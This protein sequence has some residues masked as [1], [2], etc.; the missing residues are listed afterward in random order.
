MGKSS[1]SRSIKNLWNSLYDNDAC[2]FLNKVIEGRSAMKIKSSSSELKRVSS[3]RTYTDSSNSD[4]DEAEDNDKRLR[5]SLRK[6]PP[7]ELLEKLPKPKKIKRTDSDLTQH[8][9]NTTTYPPPKHRRNTK[10]GELLLYRASSISSDTSSSN[11]DLDEAEDEEKGILASLRKLPPL[12]SSERLRDKRRNFIL[13][14][15]ENVKRVDSDSTQPISNITSP[16]TVK[17]NYSDLTQPVPNTTTYSPPKLRRNTEVR[18][19]VPYTLPNSYQ[20]TT[21]TD[22]HTARREEARREATRQARFQLLEA[23]SSASPSKSGCT[24]VSTVSIASE[25]DS[26]FLNV[27]VG[28]QATLLNKYH[29]LEYC[30]AQ[31]NNRRLKKTIL[32]PFMAQRGVSDS[33]DDCSELQVIQELPL[34]RKECSTSNTKRD[35][36]LDGECD[37]QLYVEKETPKNKVDPLSKPG[38][39]NTPAFEFPLKAYIMGE[40]NTPMLDVGEDEDSN[41]IFQ[42]EQIWTER[43]RQIIIV[44]SLA[45]LLILTT[46]TLLI[47]FA[48]HESG[49]SPY[50]QYSNNIVESNIKDMKVNAISN[51]PTNLKETQSLIVQSLKSSVIDVLQRCTTVGNVFNNDKE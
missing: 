5:S 12:I 25:D 13:P 26:N 50:K 27:S 41:S 14:R 33:D 47:L 8:I 1:T 31:R 44:V 40:E 16:D 39:E 49:I 2:T 34:N 42:Q 37:L 35:L 10:V 18:L 3:E 17:R 28:D 36:L 51:P 29:S 48:I 9:S 7:R 19:T 11:S 43:R 20:V 24:L 46:A 15:P 22:R 4:L 6:F 21:H 45:I 38:N 32:R 23:K 30:S